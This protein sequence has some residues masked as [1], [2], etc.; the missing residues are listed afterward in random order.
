MCY[1]LE[2][3]NFRSHK[4]SVF[5]FDGLTFIKGPNGVGKTHV[6][7]AMEILFFEA[8]FPETAIRH[9]ETRASISF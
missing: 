1:Q 5:E 6:I 9:G 2:L 3:S 4:N 7:R 8:T